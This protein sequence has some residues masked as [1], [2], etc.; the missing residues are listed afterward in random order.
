MLSVTVDTSMTIMA[1]TIAI[2][3]EVDRHGAEAVTENLLISTGRK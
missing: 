2:Y 1:K 3:R